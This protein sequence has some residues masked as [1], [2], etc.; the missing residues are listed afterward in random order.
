MDKQKIKQSKRSRRRGRIRAKIKGTREIPRLSVFRSNKRM[1]LQIINDASGKTLIGVSSGEIKKKDKKAVISF[2]LGKLIA[3]K[4]LDKKIKKVVFDRGG[5][6]YH[7]RVKAA[8]EGVREG[9]L[10]F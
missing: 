2:E 1:F 4:A 8:A 6:K 10:K 5:Y 9:G 7:G 3:K